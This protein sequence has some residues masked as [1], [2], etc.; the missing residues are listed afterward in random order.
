MNDDAFKQLDKEITEERGRDAQQ[1]MLEEMLWWQLWD[2]AQEFD[3][4]KE[5]ADDFNKF[6]RKFE[7][8][9]LNG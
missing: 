6:T 7:E 1:A 2:A 8:V 4:K 5:Y 9:F 3:L